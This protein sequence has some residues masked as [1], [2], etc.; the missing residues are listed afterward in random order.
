MSYAILTPCSPLKVNRRFGRICC[1]HFYGWRVSQARNQHEAGRQVKAVSCLAYSST[2]KMEASSSSETSVGFWLTTLSSIPED[3]TLHNH[4]CE[5][6]KSYILI[7]WLNQE[8]QGADSRTVTQ[9]TPRLFWNLKVHYLIQNNPTSVFILSQMSPIHI[10]IPYFFN[11]EFNFILA[12]LE[13]P[14]IINYL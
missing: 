5:N 12:L 6:F 11:I 1:L 8:K 14:Q 9:K 10:L 3:S 13:I 7:R 4:R 2:L